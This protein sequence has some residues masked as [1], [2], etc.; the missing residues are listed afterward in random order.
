MELEWK[1]MVCNVKIATL[2]PKVAAKKKKG[3][4]FSQV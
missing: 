3:A 2:E 1:N 4:L